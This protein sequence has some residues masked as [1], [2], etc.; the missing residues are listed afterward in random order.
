MPAIPALGRLS[1]EGWEFK[2]SPSYIVNLSQSWPQEILF[3]GTE[4]KSTRGT[5]IKMEQK[6]RE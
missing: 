5:G 2:S 1:Q 6:L 4:V 3:D